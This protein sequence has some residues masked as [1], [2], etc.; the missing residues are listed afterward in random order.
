M[1][2]QRGTF[3][4][5]S[6]LPALAAQSPRAG[7]GPRPREGASAP[8]APRA[9]STLR[10]G[11]R[12]RAALHRL[13]GSRSAVDPGEAGGREDARDRHVE[14]SWLV[15]RGCRRETRANERA[16]W[17]EGPSGVGQ[18]AWP[19]HGAAQGCRQADLGAPL[20][21]ETAALSLGSAERRNAAGARP[22]RGL[23]HP[24]RHLPASGARRRGA[25]RAK[26]TRTLH[27]QLRTP[28][29]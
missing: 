24:D 25:N 13:R 8:A 27:G 3:S 5:V 2:T 21:A 11:R 28:H 16:V 22:G 7:R 18:A 12:P 4:D 19:P 10:S 29:P 6:T 20:N 14:V 23:R 26:T 1:G 15:P 17:G 9:A